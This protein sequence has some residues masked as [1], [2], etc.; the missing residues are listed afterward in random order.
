MRRLRGGEL[1]SMLAKATI[2]PRR[3]RHADA[4]IMGGALVL[5]LS[6]E[7]VDGP[8]R[9]GPTVIGTIPVS[10]P[11]VSTLVPLNGTGPAYTWDSDGDGVP[12]AVD[13][14]PTSAPIPTGGVAPNPPVPSRDQSCYDVSKFGWM[15]EVSLDGLDKKACYPA[16]AYPISDVTADFEQRRGFV[17][18]GAATPADEATVRAVGVAGGSWPS[19]VPVARCMYAVDYSMPMGALPL[20]Y[21]DST[22]ESFAGLSTY[23]IHYASSG[24]NGGGVFSSGE[25]LGL[26]IIDPGADTLT[27]IITVPTRTPAE[28]QL[29]RLRFTRGV[30]YADKLLVVPNWIEPVVST[31]SG[32]SAYAD[33]TVDGVIPISVVVSITSVFPV[34]GIP[35][36]RP[37]IPPM[38]WRVI[39]TGLD[40]ALM[41][42]RAARGVAF[43][44]TSDPSTL[45]LV[46]AIEGVPQMT[47]DDAALINSDPFSTLF[48]GIMLNNGVD[49][50][51]GALV[52]G[53][54]GQAQLFLNDVSPWILVPQ[55]IT[56][57][58][59]H[60]RQGGG[61]APTYRPTSVASYAKAQNDQTLMLQHFSIDD[62]VASGPEGAF[63][64]SIE[65]EWPSFFGTAPAATSEANPRYGNRWT[66]NGDRPDCWFDRTSFDGSAGD[67]SGTTADHF[68][69]YP[70]G[71]SEP[72]SVAAL[73]CPAALADWIDEMP[74][75]HDQDTA[76]AACNEF[77]TA[78]ANLDSF[79]TVSLAWLRSLGPEGWWCAGKLEL[80]NGLDCACAVATFGAACGTICIPFTDDCYSP[81]DCE[82]CLQPINIFAG[83][84]EAIMECVLRA[85][86]DNEHSSLTNDKHWL[87][88][89]RRS[90]RRLPIPMV[91]MMRTETT[92]GNPP[93]NS[94]LSAI[95][96]G[97]DV[98][99]HAHQENDWNWI[100]ADR[101]AIDAQFQAIASR[102][103]SQFDGIENEL[104][105]LVP[106][107]NWQNSPHDSEDEEFHNQGLYPVVSMEVSG[108]ISWVAEV[109]PDQFCSD[110]GF[111]INQEAQK[112]GGVNNP[113]LPSTSCGTA[114]KSNAPFQVTNWP[115]HY[116]R[117]LFS[118][119]SSQTVSS[120]PASYMALD[121]AWPGGSGSLS[122]AVSLGLQ[123]WGSFPHR[124]SFL[125]DPILD[126]GHFDAKVEIHPP[127]IVSMDLANA[128]DKA[129]V[130]GT[131]VAVFG[132]V[133][134][135]VY[136]RIEFDLWPGP[137]PNASSTLVTHGLTEQLS[138]V[139]LGPQ[140][141]PDGSDSF[142]FV[143]DSHGP[144]SS[145]STPTL[146]CFP[147]PTHFPNHVHCVYND[148]AGVGLYMGAES[149]DPAAQSFGIDRQD[150]DF[151]EG[152]GEETRA[153]R[154]TPYF[155]TSRFD[156]RF[157]LGWK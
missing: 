116:G 94:G 156:A 15:H 99:F 139:A 132:W 24:G 89:S 90:S 138:D 81:C 102:G 4:V 109:W 65:T 128:S 41:N 84:G 157:F 114:G 69:P 105:F 18:V 70:A 97:D 134:P 86:G 57:L 100:F 38:D 44:G 27:G 36:G 133:N 95:S 85:V 35:P 143:I 52:F 58:G 73:Q 140:G 112:Y 123:D 7:R 10:L 127:H 87:D 47:V 83:S 141:N 31:G 68:L 34:T 50:G 119:I 101:S 28:P 6:S 64:R 11:P 25:G 12:D 19:S 80:T 126:C 33:P 74:E 67:G 29:D 151:A 130:S 124:I 17:V 135:T 93:K 76:T 115:A 96:S 21:I 92:P 155:A 9:A 121:P 62:Y 152:S 20:F 45:P 8:A 103:S 39:P 125:G 5:V 55:T 98:T 61:S 106:R 154:L 63:V 136:G 53:P 49:P 110:M 131:V 51:N 79:D 14:C 142:G 117:G 78:F 16:L 82:K 118:G 91:G 66:S 32:T 129:G 137:R 147:T 148:S 30:L 3:W 13:N 153:P 40:R 111:D 149:P 1:L 146:E 60:V 26:P 71:Y 22:G 113:A 77:A 43:A 75:A 23:Y 104:E 120:S 72:G 88:V 107:G 2:A 56:A 122:N 145:S 150:T 37:V 144:W 54:S 108:D 42:D 59:Q 46:N 48:L